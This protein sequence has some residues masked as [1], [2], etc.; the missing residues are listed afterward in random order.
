MVSDESKDFQFPV[1][2][3]RSKP[4]PEPDRPVVG[5]VPPRLSRP[6][7][8]IWAPGARAPFVPHGLVWL[9]DGFNR[10]GKAHFGAEWIGSEGN[11]CGNC[12][13][14]PRPSAVFEGDS[15][16]VVDFDA[17]RKGRTT[18]AA[19]L[20]IDLDRRT[21]PLTNREWCEATDRWQLFDACG[22]GLIRRREAV[23]DIIH[24]AL[25]DR[26]LVAMICPEGSDP[27]AV[28]K[29]A[30]NCSRDKVWKRLTTGSLADADPFCPP[31]IFFFHEETLETF[32]AELSVQCGANEG[33]QTSD[34]RPHVRARTVD[35]LETTPKRVPERDIAEWIKEAVSNRVRIGKTIEGL[36]SRF[37]DHQQPG[38][39]EMRRRHRAQWEEVHGAGSY[40]SPGKP[41]RPEAQQSQE[42]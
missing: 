1:C 14:F 3:S 5:N 35:P 31:I 20:G 33:E 13:A 25:A 42:T 8:D 16:V 18:A 6:A 11:Y 21:I 7:P 19:M 34:A 4:P 24:R 17:Y 23:V 15:D 28:K 26:D 29:A 22:P 39:D 9:T 27:I 30:W 36:A 41:A 2:L 10:V 40:P 37:P 12:P 32:L 38:R